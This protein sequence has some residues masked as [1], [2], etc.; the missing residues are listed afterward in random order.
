MSPI[1]PESQPRQPMTP[2]EPA[3]ITSALQPGR[4]RA[5]RK[6]LDAIHEEAM[7]HHA[8]SSVAQRD[9]EA[10][11]VRPAL[12]PDDQL[13]YL[14]S[15]LGNADVVHSR[16]GYV[17]LTEMFA[18]FGKTAGN[19]LSQPRTKRD[20]RYHAR[21]LGV[22][23]Q[24]MKFR[25]NGPGGATWG[26]QT[27]AVACAEVLSFDYRTWSWDARLGTPEER[28]SPGP[29]VP[30][31][32][33]NLL[34]LFRESECRAPAGEPRKVRPEDGHYIVSSALYGWRGIPCL[35]VLW[36]V[37]CREKPVFDWRR[38]YP[39]CPDAHHAT[40]ATDQFLNWAEVKQLAGYL[41]AKG[42]RDIDVGDLMPI[43]TDLTK[44]YVLSNLPDAQF[45]KLET[46]LNYPLGFRCWGWVVP[47]PAC[48]SLDVQVPKV[49]ICTVSTKFDTVCALSG[50][51]F[52]VEPIIAFHLENEPERFVRSKY[53]QGMDYICPEDMAD[54]LELYAS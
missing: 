12:T 1:Q 34:A 40:R 53:A 6:L 14:H 17:N 54:L 33:P 7:A 24:D 18:V 37:P 20:I 44:P 52:T 29:A 22:R 42:H 2:E 9:I 10:G 23:A 13:A 25:T 32:G 4:W 41:K 47:M 43:E 3:T 26:H 15:I 5:E 19:F 31:Y 46:Q 35:R 36:I 50:E 39:N 45:I 30:C 51:R 11:Q 8:V 27:L 28:C 21:K 16:D 49:Q 48:P 38:L